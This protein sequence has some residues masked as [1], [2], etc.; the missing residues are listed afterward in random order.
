MGLLK[1]ITTSSGFDVEPA[2]F[3]VESL[4]VTKTELQFYLTPYASK[5]DYEEGKSSIDGPFRYSILPDI[6]ESAPNFFR[7]VYSYLIN[8][9]SFVESESVAEEALR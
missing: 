9:E 6:S 5:K 1:N 4:I 7:Q 2:Y 3:V 8:S